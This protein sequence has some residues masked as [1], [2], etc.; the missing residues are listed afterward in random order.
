MRAIATGSP[1]ALKQ[2]E[3]AAVVVGEKRSVGAVREKTANEKVTAVDVLH[4]FAV[5][6]V[7]EKFARESLVVV[8]VLGEAAG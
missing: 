6:E 7:S 8:I 5:V 1:V 3:A 2:R 4:Y